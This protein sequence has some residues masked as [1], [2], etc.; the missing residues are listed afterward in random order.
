MIG[1]IIYIIGYII[2]LLS[3]ILFEC[4]M[5]FYEKHIQLELPHFVLSIFSWGTVLIVLTILF[6][7][8]LA[9][10]EIKNPFYKNDTL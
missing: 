9:N 4:K 5:R 6:I 10:L 1:L 2:A 8:Y 7:N 3:V